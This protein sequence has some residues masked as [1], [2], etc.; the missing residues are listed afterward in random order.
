MSA[1]Y[2][3]VDGSS[4]GFACTALGYTNPKRRLTL[5]DLDTHGTIGVLNMMRGLCDR[6]PHLIP[7]VCWDGVSWR[8]KFFREYKA[9]RS[10]V[11][12]VAED[13][14]EIQAPATGHQEVMMDA[15]TSFVQQR[16]YMIKGLRTLGVRQML[17]A[18]MEADDLAAKLVRKLKTP[19][20]KIM[21]VSGDRDWIQLVSKGVSW[22]NPIDNGAKIKH[23]TTVNF[24]DATGVKTTRQF[25]EMK[26]MIGDISDNIPGVGGIG[27]KGAI[28]FLEIFGSVS[29]FQN[30]WLDKTIKD[31]EK[32]P[33]KYRDFATEQDKQDRFTRNMML[34]DLNWAKV[35][36]PYNLT[37]FKGAFD[38]DHFRVFCNDL[39]FSSITKNPKWIEPFQALAA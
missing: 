27:E 12:V 37:V 5:G 6:Y 33:K 16:P 24:E 13:G 19:N 29:A 10:Q 36:S 17:A 22:F 1:G 9:N 20:N 4:I 34:M 2:M 8:K 3:I 30:M 28:K 38:E 39:M 23:V 18:N 26:A 11:A 25:I 7:I 15:K 31:P 32:L 14:A 21:L 35:P